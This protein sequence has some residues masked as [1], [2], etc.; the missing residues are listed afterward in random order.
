MIEC[1]LKIRRKHE[2]MNNVYDED[3]INENDIF[4]KQIQKKH[5]SSF[6]HSQIFILPIDDSY[7]SLN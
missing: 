6:K 1:T 2:C 7:F 4:S 3:E 5:T